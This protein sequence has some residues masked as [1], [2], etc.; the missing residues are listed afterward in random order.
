MK[1]KMNSVRGGGIAS[2]KLLA[3]VAVLAVMFAAVAAILPATDDADAADITF[4]SGDII[5]SF[6]IKDG[7][8]AVIN[9]DL[10]IKNGATLTVR[11]GA[12]LTIK[13]GVKVTVDGAKEVADGQTKTSVPASFIVEAGT[14]GEEATDGARVIVNGQIIVGENGTAMIGAVKNAQN[15]YEYSAAFDN[16]KDDVYAGTFVYGT[17]AVQKGGVAYVAAQIMNGGALSVTSTGTK[18]SQI[19]GDIAMMSGSVVEVKGVINGNLNITASEIDQ[20]KEVSTKIVALDAKVSVTGT[21]AGENLTSAKVSDL[22]ITADAQSAT[23]YV[24]NN[25]GEKTKKTIYAPIVAVSGTVQNGDVLAISETESVEDATADKDGKKAL[26]LSAS[27]VVASGATLDVKNGGLTVGADFVVAGTVTATKYTDEVK[28]ENGKVTTPKSGAEICLNAGEITVSGTVEIDGSSVKNSKEAEK[29]VLVIDGGKVTVANYNDKAQNVKDFKGAYYTYDS[30]SVNYLVACEL[31]E[32]IK[33]ADGKT[34]TDVTVCGLT[35]S[36]TATADGKYEGAYEVSESFVLA[37]GVTLTVHNGLI[38]G[39]EYVITVPVDGVIASENANIVVN[40]KLVDNTMGLKTTSEDGFITAQVVIKDEESA[41]QTF[42]SLA[43]AIKDTASG[44]IVLAGPVVLDKDMT[45]PA[46]VTVVIGD[47]SFTVSQNVVLTVQGVLDDSNGKLVTEC[48]YDKN[49]AGSVVVENYVIVA[50]D[51]QYSN[52]E[53]TENDKFGFNVPGVYVTVDIDGIEASTFVMAVPV[54]ATYSAQA[55][56]AVFQGTVSYK[57][58]LTLNGEDK[59]LSVGETGVVADVTIDGTLTLAGYTLSI[60]NGTFT[61]KIADEAGAV[62]LTKVKN[63][64][65]TVDGKATAVPVVIAYQKDDEG[66]VSLLLSGTPG[67]STKDGK[68]VSEI[69]IASGTLTISSDVDVKNLKSFGVAADT[70]LA[71]SAKLTASDMTVEGT[72]DVAKAGSVGLDN[73][74]VLGTVKI[75]DDSAGIEATKNVYV[76]ADGKTFTGAAASVEGKALTADLIY[77]LAG[78]S[79]SE[80]IVKKLESTTFT[81]QDVLKVTVYGV[82]DKVIAIADPEVENAKFVNWVD[83]KGNDVAKSEIKTGM[84]L[85]AKIDE[86]IYSIRVIGDN[87]IGSVAIDGNVLQKSSNLFDVDDLKAGSHTITYDVKYGYEGTVVIKVNGTAISGTTFTLSGTSEKD[88]NV[89]IDLS[90]T[91]PVKTVVPEPAEDS[92]DGMGLTDYLLIVL[93]VLIVI[94]AV[95]VAMRL[96]RS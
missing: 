78:S 65:V 12:T 31:S 58:D 61:G 76:G 33:A 95:I 88:T 49:K 94:L 86:N 55:D 57:G 24:A 70:V 4:I 35:G 91:A 8:I 56:E 40:G 43:L 3:A 75:A 28:D 22:K 69:A 96:M 44:K 11:A 6:E 93:V 77:V 19:S 51:A 72:L 41:V 64:T 10:N 27:V 5:N 52:E 39:E 36:A 38:V 29:S 74:T 50:S 30:N 2:K 13:E 15:S 9:E 25:S 16:K 21:V 73:L 46:G 79:I 37:S 92:D 67:E 89:S 82:K 71:V 34:V 84:K 20:S 7:T 26:D 60:D 14:S 23:G 87:G 54:F 48:K 47:F 68:K 90:G 42:T 83:E 81:V 1:T 45:I 85:T 59:T 18:V 80:D 62:Q 63:G 53:A 66:V 17:I 32:A